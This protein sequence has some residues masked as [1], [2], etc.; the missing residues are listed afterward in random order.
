L[1]KKN[2]QKADLYK[3]DKNLLRDFNHLLSEKGT[4]RFGFLLSMGVESFN[5]KAQLK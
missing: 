2:G 4:M 5:T 1:K 3:L